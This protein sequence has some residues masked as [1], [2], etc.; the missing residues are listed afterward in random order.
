[1]DLEH[2]SFDAWVCDVREGGERL[3]DLV[4]V[5]VIEIDGLR[6]GFR[7]ELKVVRFGLLLVLASLDHGPPIGVAELVE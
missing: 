4:L 6:P 5:V 2:S 1:V 7:L 3:C